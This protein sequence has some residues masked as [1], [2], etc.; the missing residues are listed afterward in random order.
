[1]IDAFINCQ[2]ER[3]REKKAHVVSLSLSLHTWRIRGATRISDGVVCF[4]LCVC[5][6]VCVCCVSVCV[7]I[8]TMAPLS[9]DACMMRPAA[10]EEKE[11]A[12][13]WRGMGEKRGGGGGGGGGE[14]GGG[15]GGG[16]VVF[17]KLCGHIGCSGAF[18]PS[19]ST[20][21]STD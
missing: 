2:E 21:E 9:Y 1:M 4:A 10:R 13:E 11:G 18:H 5:V 17:S 6:C 20:T 15:G 3:E 8:R 7:L 14:G 16:E 12:G 19:L